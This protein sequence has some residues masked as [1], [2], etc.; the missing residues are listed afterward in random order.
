MFAARTLHYPRGHLLPAHSHDE[1]QL[2]YA[3]AGVMEVETE[4]GR[5][6][7]PPQR[8]VWLPPGA[9]H[10][11][12]MR[13][14]VDMR[15][16]YLAPGW[17]TARAE[18]EAIRL[19]E[20]SRP[21]VL[22]VGPLMREV[23]VELV[24]LGGGTADERRVG[25]LLAVLQDEIARAPD[26]PLHLPMPADRRARRVAEALR[27]DP[28]DPR[29]LEAWA[30]SCG[31]S[32]RTLMRLFR[33]ETG[34]SFGAWRQQARLLAGLA[35]LA[36]GGGVTAAASSSGYATAS[37]FSAMFRRALGVPPG[38]FFAHPD[39]GPRAPEA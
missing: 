11:V 5:W 30:A 15:T 1:A 27:R 39:H 21:A 19:A 8:S 37:A 23:I 9:A 31:A 7:V 36:E 33:R 20:M 34:L 13:S 26:L 18:G 38:T 12:E 25:H 4:A 32:R 3:V 16:L 22:T 6:V 2:L 14:E 29:S 28:G 24:R 17:T 10:T 35:A